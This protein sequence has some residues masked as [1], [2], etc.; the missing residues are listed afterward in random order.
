MATDLQNDE[1]AVLALIA[2][3]AAD[4]S[5]GA[6]RL[7]AAWRLVMR[8]L[9]VMHT[10]APV[11]F[12]IALWRFTQ[13]LQTGNWLAFWVAVAGGAALLVLPVYLYLY[14]PTA[15]VSLDSHMFT[16]TIV[17]SQATKTLCRSCQLRTRRLLT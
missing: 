5:P 3:A 11:V 7:R 8:V 14:D 1:A 10:L 2:A 12:G 6:E 17:W 13:A 4:T 15:T 16:C 9:I